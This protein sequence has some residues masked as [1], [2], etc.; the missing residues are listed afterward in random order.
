MGHVAVICWQKGSL[1]AIGDAFAIA[2]DDHHVSALPQTVQVAV[3]LQ[4]HFLSVILFS[5]R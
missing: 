4:I 5:K 3:S 2:D 1:L